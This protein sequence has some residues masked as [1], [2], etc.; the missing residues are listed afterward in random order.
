[1]QKRRLGSGECSNTTAHSKPESKPRLQPKAAADPVNIVRALLSLHGQGAAT[2]ADHP[3]NRTKA[4]LWRSALREQL[5]AYTRNS[6]PKRCIACINNSTAENNIRSK[7]GDAHALKCR[8]G[9][10][11]GSTNQVLACQIQQAFR[12]ATN[13]Q[14]FLCVRVYIVCVGCMCVFVY[15]A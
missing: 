13:W 14:L 15:S 5:T 11:Q 4:L 3:V 1:M 9:R 10:P 8:V 2:N 12:L 7:Q 6:T